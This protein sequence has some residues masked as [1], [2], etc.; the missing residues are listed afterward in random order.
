MSDCEFACP[1]S[2]T[3]AGKPWPPTKGKPTCRL[4]ADYAAATNP[5]TRASIR[6]AIR[7]RLGWMAE[8]R[9]VPCEPE[10]RT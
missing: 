7:R 2:C 9:P 5:V 8:V 6:A 10:A 3:Y 4:F 1:K